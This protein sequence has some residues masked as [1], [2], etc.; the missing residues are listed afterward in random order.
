M[1]SQPKGCLKHNNGICGW[2]VVWRKKTKSKQKPTP[3]FHEFGAKNISRDTVSNS[4]L[5]AE[6]LEFLEAIHKSKQTPETFWS[7]CMVKLFFLNVEASLFVIILNCTEG[8]L[9]IYLFLCNST[10]QLK[11]LKKTYQNFLFWKMLK[12]G[13]FQNWS[14]RQRTFSYALKYTRDKGTDFFQ[15]IC[16]TSF[17]ISSTHQHGNISFYHCCSLLLLIMCV[18][19]ISWLLYLTL[20]ILQDTNMP[21]CK[22][23]LLGKPT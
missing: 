1:L 11:T 21:I 14:E 15:S 7:I 6:I 9:F 23:S 19:I 20:S 18:L 17:M 8:F 12:E 10:E 22:Y 5:G 13:W 16:I 2:E 3:L 4:L